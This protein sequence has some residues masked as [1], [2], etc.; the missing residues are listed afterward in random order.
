MQGQDK[1]IL[2]YSLTCCL[3]TD[4]QTHRPKLCLLL[5]VQSKALPVQYSVQLPL[6]LTVLTVRPHPAQGAG[7]AAVGSMTQAPIPAGTLEFTA[8]AKPVLGTA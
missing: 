5:R 6:T 4:P 7:T 8:L 1:W 2:R 3:Y